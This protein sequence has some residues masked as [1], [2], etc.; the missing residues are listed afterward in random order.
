MIELSHV[1][2]AY[3]TED[4][5]R[6]VLDDV[7]AVFPD[8]RGVAVFGRNGQG[9]STLVRILAGTEPADAGRVRRTGRV[10][11]PLGFGGTFHPLLTGREN[12][13]FLARLHGAEEE[14]ALA[15]VED[16]AELGAYWRMPVGTYSS[17]MRA[18]VAFGACLALDFDTYLV[19]E[20]IA[21]G[22]ARFRARCLDTFAARTG[23]AG[24]VFVSHDIS[25]A[26][27]FCE[28]GAVLADGRLRCFDDIEDAIAAHE[29]QVQETASR[30]AA[31]R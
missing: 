21:V 11:F 5:P 2:K 27:A 14:D 17:G 4:G 24:L 25:L 29:D 28:S 1:R 6:V 7:S 3:R 19:D 12:M 15:F 8:G 9:K 16:F 18:R 13:R 20:V 31:L 26:R 30:E 22:D 10:S 23:H